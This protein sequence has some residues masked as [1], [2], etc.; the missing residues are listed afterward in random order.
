MKPAG[1]SCAQWGWMQRKLTQ[2]A[3][4]RV[5]KYAG[6]QLTRVPAFVVSLPGN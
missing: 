3:K 5:E 1:L 4:I 6:K 2:N